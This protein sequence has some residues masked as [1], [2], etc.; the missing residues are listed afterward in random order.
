MNEHSIDSILFTVK[1]TRKTIYDV[2]ID[3]KER[4]FR[5][6][7]TD[8][9]GHTHGPAID[10]KLR[11]SSVEKFLSSLNE[12]DFIS[13]KKLEQGIL[14][15]K[16]KSATVMYYIDEKVYYTK[17]N[18]DADL[19]FLHKAIEQLIGTTFGTYEFYK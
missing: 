6:E 19:A 18:T 2:G 1:Q 10:G 3:L 17:G 11:R 8:L 16:L 9:Y 15:L 4:E 13:W 7:I 5:I 14:P 12:A